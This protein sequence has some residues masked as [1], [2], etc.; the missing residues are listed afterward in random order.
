MS[1]I[2][3]GLKMAQFFGASCLRQEG[4]PSHT[5][6]NT[7]TYLRRENVTFIEPH[8]APKHPGLECLRCFSTD[9]LSTSTIHDNQQAEAGNRH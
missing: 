1:H 2:Q 9:G 3:D 7:P 8:V 4:A 6:R 5:A